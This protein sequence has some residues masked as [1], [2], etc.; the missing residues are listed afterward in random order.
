M[1][2]YSIDKLMHETRQLAAKYRETT[3]STLPVTG[4]IARF[5][6]AK[7]LS[8]QLI[9]DPTLG[10]DAM[11]TGDRQDLRV[12]IKGRVIFEDSRSNVR[13]G[14]INPDGR[15][16]NIIMVLFNDDYL[17]VEM[18][19][20]TSQD[21]ETAISPNSKSKKRGA[22]SVARFKIISQLV[23]TREDGLSSEVWDNRSH[24]S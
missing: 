2:L 1:E 24:S 21:I 13:I 14:Q 16:D 6:V 15:W 19:E 23:W 11:G 8:L 22:M 17:P 3:G 18:Y 20:A 10:Y 4:E 7:A 9:D 5:D 12:L